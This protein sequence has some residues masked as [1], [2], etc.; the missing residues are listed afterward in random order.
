MSSVIFY[1]PIGRTV[2]NLYPNDTYDKFVFNN[3]NH[4]TYD[5]N[6][7]VLLD[8]RTDADISN[9]VS[10]YFASI[11][12]PDT[13][14]TWYQKRLT[15]P[16]IPPEELS[17]AR[18]TELHANTPTITFFDSLGRS[19]LTFEHNGFKEDDGTARQFPARLKMD[20][21]GNTREVRDTIEQNGDSRGR[22]VMLYDYDMVGNVIHQT[23][24]DA[25]DLWMLNDILGNAIRGW[26]SRKHTFITQYDTLR[27]PIR[28]YVNTTDFVNQV[29]V[30]STLVERI[31]YGEQ[32]PLD[33][34]LNLRGKVYLH[35]DQAG[36]LRTEI[37]D[38]KGN[39]LTSKRQ[40]TRQYKKK[41][42]WK[43]VDDIIPVNNATKLDIATVE[44][45]FASLPEED[46]L[47]L[48]QTF[49]SST[50]Y[51]AL[52][53]PVLMET[54]HSDTMLPNLIK[55]SY[56]KANMLEKVD[57]NLR[58]EQQNGKKV[59]TPFVINIDYDAKGRRTMIE[60][61]SGFVDNSQHGVVT[62]YEYDKFTSQLIHI[63]TRR[64]L[65]IF[66]D[67][68]PIPQ[69]SSWPGCNIQ[70]LRYRYDPVGNITEITDDA[71]QSIFFHGHWVNPSS[72]YTYDPLYRLIEARGREHLGQ[73]GGRP[74]AHSNN[75]DRRA[76]KTWSANDG[77]AMG[78]YIEEYFYDAVGNFESMKHYSID[79]PSEPAWSRT[80][81]YNAPNLIPEESSSKHNNQLSK[82]TISGNNPVT[83]NYV[84]DSHGNIIRMPHLA[85]HPN[86]NDANMHW[87]H[88]DQLRQVDMDG[89]G[90]A[91]YVYD[92][93]TGQRIRKV[94]ERSPGFVEERIYLGSIEIFKRRNGS[95]IITLE[96]ETLHIMDDEQRIALVETRTNGQEPD[97]PDQLI[98]YQFS[99]HLGSASL[100]LDEKTQII[101]YEEYTPY[102]STSFQSGRILAEVKLKRYRYA[103]MERDEESGFGYHGAR[104]YTPWLGRWTSCDPIGISSGLNLYVY[105][106]NSPSVLVDRTGNEGK[107]FRYYWTEYEERTGK[108]RPKNASRFHGIG[109]PVEER[110]RKENQRRSKRK[111]ELVRGN[112]ELVSGN[113]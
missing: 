7:T 80:Y 10:K 106:D 113:L 36:V 12:N 38:F 89:G 26:D 82:T 112:R 99:N 44:T 60:Y 72:E 66:P 105:A 57:V 14:K 31:I 56:N 41:I 46:Q 52:N 22:I 75:D 71:Q 34:S 58:S 50:K 49:T 16:T 3:W 33:I 48:E 70:N 61:G 100:E 79:N 9:I 53:R 103:G 84:H 86:P 30:T 51:D 97:I 19:F 108:D 107:K 39:I 62:T 65:V 90:T 64:N 43:E 102:G 1:N 81:E 5:V 69:D 27:R 8:P 110:I 111:W 23:S 42:N 73:I 59:W 96:R 98:R 91:Y 4:R 93:T 87:N 74:V 63:L 25:G 95:G 47:E 35:L 29:Q 20:I 54:P 83:E 85:N 109:G 77:N 67:D 88:N 55:P 92:A 78:E 2:A 15:D 104:Y 17:A 11:S 68:C 94:L 18:K 28:A 13:W 45:A 40:L 6:D 76:G 21:E 101:S 32:H 37:C 24:M